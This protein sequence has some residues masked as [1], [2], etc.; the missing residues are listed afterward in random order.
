MCSDFWIEKNLLEMSPEEWEALCDGCGKC[1]LHKFEDEDTREVFY[2]NVSC[3]LLDT[4]QCRCRDYP[5]RRERVPGCL[6]LTPQRVAQFKWLPSTC[7]YRRLA[8]GKGLFTWHP[9][10][11]GDAQS[12]HTAG[13][14]VR[15]KVISEQDIDMQKL[16]DYVVEWFD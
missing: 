15:G 12:V 11:S 9:L 4:F 2:T 1:C 6:L 13:I 5:H 16:E 7:A 3:W 10:L 8:E 14:S